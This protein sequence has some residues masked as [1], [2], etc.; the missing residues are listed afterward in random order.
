MKIQQTFVKDVKLRKP[1]SFGPY[2][3]SNHKEQWI[4]ISEGCPNNCPYCYEPTEQK[5]FG[6]PEITRNF[7]KIMDMNLLAKP[8]ALSTI[9]ELGLKRV[10]GKRV[11][12]ELICGLDHRFL[13]QEIADALHDARFQRIRLAWDWH[14]NDQFN[15]KTALHKLLNASYESQDIMIFMICNWRIA[16]EENCRKL[17]LCKVWRVKVADCYFDGQVFPHV[18][19]RFWTD[20]QNK[21]FRRKVRKH[22]HL[23]I[24]GIDPEVKNHE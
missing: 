15:I 5:W 1:Y 23:V 9:Q 4:R 17:D 14:V 10:N 6:V 7:V 8:Q 18:N 20:E 24:F 2:N 16:F 3:K 22:N 13:S 11:T 12:Y 21:V 19:P